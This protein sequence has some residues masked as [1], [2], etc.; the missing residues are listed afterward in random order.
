MQSRLLQAVV[1]FFR[2][3][4]KALLCLSFQF[5]SE[6][7]SKPSKP[8]V[9]T[10][11]HHFSQLFTPPFDFCYKVTFPPSLFGS[12]AS[13]PDYG[14]DSFSSD[15]NRHSYRRSQSPATWPCPRGGADFRRV[16]TK[17]F[18]VFLVA[19]NFLWK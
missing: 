12:F 9:S 10:A 15:F 13:L 16:K 6:E 2:C 18:L 8:S 3:H 5:S 1:L 14:I 17:D 7:M 4:W 19:K 11:G